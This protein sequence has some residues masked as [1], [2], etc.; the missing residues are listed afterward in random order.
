LK[1][2]KVKWLIVTGGVLLSS[3]EALSNL[4][5][6]SDTAIAA[7]WSRDSSQEADQQLSPFRESVPANHDGTCRDV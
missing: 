3:L 6:V 5:S 2:I 7:L 4:V 1:K